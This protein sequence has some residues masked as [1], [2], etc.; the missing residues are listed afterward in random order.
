MLAVFPCFSTGFYYDCYWPKTKNTTRINKTAYFSCFRSPLIYGLY[1]K[2]RRKKRDSQFFK[3]CFWFYWD[4]FG[5]ILFNSLFA[6][7]NANLIENFVFNQRSTTSA[8]KKPSA[9]IVS[10][11]KLSFSTPSDIKRGYRVGYIRYSSV[12]YIG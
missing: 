7:K 4:L 1:R 12:L 2:E 11:I 10:W 8:K 3:F 9:E 6:L 5:N